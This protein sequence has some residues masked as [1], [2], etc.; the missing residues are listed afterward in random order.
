MQ[1]GPAT[2]RGGVGA[3][4]AVA[5]LSFALHLTVALGLCTATICPA[6]CEQDSHEQLKAGGGA[7]TVGR[8]MFSRMREST[9][10]TTSVVS[11]SIRQSKPPSPVRSAGSCSGP[12]G[13]DQF[14]RSTGRRAAVN[15]SPFFDCNSRITASPSHGAAVSQK[16]HVDF[17]AEEQRGKHRKATKTERGLHGGVLGL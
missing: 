17:A 4:Q 10:I 3:S 11:T 13:T 6:P 16:G 1:L 12:S 14:C 15:L 8:T 7:L 9:E 5:C 2:V